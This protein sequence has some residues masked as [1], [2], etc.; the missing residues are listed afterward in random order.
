MRLR[1]NPSGF[2]SPETVCV[3]CGRSFDHEEEQD[4]RHRDQAAQRD[5]PWVNA[6]RVTSL[7][8]LAGDVDAMLDEAGLKNAP[9]REYVRLWAEHTGAERVEVV[10]ASDDARLIR[11]AVEAEEILPAGERPDPSWTMP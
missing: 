10:S 11:E 7:V 5:T 4:L 9:V 2:A 8:D 6:E 3:E 1:E